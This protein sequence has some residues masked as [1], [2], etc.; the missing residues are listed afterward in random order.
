MKQ[1]LRYALGMSAATMAV[2][3][4]TTCAVA[5]DVAARVGSTVITHEQLELHAASQLSKIRQDEYNVRAR[6]LNEMIDE[7]LIE[8]AAKKAGKTSE[9]FMAENL[10]AKVTEPN[11]AEI[12]AFYE[13]VKAQAQGQT[14]EQLRPRL[15]ESLKNQ[16]RGKVYGELIAQMRKE[17]GV[18]VLLE[19]PRAA[20]T[21]DDDPALGP[22]SAPITIVAFS[23]YQCPYCK[24]VEPTIKE[25]RDKYGDKLQYVFRDY[26]LSF[27][28]FAQ[29]AG[30]AAGCAM[31]QGKFWEMH[32]KL[33]TN[34]TQLQTENLKK[35]AGELGLNAD[36]FNSCLDSGKRAK[37]VTDDMEA[38]SKVG[39]TGTPAFFINGRFLNGAVPIDQFTEIIEDELARAAARS[40]APADAKKDSK[41]KS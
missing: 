37:E 32:E 26:P 31:E 25:L 35:Y 23:D 18:T 40:A 29:K 33:F 24:R 6:A 16:Q 38:G 1:L 39:V 21:V 7:M 41:K 15:I 5:E 11:E 19:P 28:P 22:T 8:A 2:V 13:R 12:S 10:D 36:Q 27:H 9:A 34:N 17:T 3:G 4:L 20:V 30:E 14:L